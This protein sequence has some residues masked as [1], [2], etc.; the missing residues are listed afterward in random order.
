MVAVSNSQDALALCVE[1]RRA[2]ALE[3]PGIAWE[4]VGE[5]QQ[6]TYMGF[7]GLAADGRRLLDRTRLFAENYRLKYAELPGVK[8]IAY[9]IGGTRE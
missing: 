6:G 5:I 3:E 8:D 1:R 7:A 2:S 9:F 4:K